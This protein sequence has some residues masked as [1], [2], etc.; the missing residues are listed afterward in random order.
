MCTNVPV[1]G[2][3]GRYV[4]GQL[5][6]GRRNEMARFRVITSERTHG[7]RRHGRTAGTGGKGSSMRRPLRTIGLALLVAALGTSGSL[8]RASLGPIA[9]RDVT[10]AR[11]PR[12]AAAAPEEPGG[13]VPGVTPPPP[14]EPAA[15]GGHPGGR[16]WEVASR[17]PDGA[18]GGVVT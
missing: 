12:G 2:R 15:T 13:T 3:R 14:P 7:G 5:A 9:R 6:P 1:A 16:R 8:S 11:G 4:C 10:A 17:T 18:R